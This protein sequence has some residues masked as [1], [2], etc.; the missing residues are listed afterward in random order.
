MGSTIL[1]RQMK[2]VCLAKNTFEWA[3][4]ITVILKFLI[5]LCL[6]IHVLGGVVQCG[7]RDAETGGLLQV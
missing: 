1:I 7:S 6:N 2:A 4:R 5:N 3:F